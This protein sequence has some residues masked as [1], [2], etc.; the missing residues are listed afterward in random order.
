M[1]HQDRR[2][3]IV[4]NHRVVKQVAGELI[5]AELFGRGKARCDARWKPR[6]L[7]L[8]ALLTVTEGWGTLTTGFV[9]ARKILIKVCAWQPGRA[10][11][12][13]RGRNRDRRHN[14]PSRS[15]TKSTPPKCG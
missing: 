3:E 9:R 11:T 15:R 13:P 5:P 10:R 1:P 12:R 6:M 2:L 14:R 4:V 8:G 7:A